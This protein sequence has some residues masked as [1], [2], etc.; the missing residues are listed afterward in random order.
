MVYIAIGNYV[1]NI[2]TLTDTKLQE[3]RNLNA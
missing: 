2:S 1:K 3:M